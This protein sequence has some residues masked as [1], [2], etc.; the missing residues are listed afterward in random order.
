M[1]LFLITYNFTD[2]INR[3]ITAWRNWAAGRHEL[4]VKYE[5]F[6]KRRREKL[7]KSPV[8]YH[9]EVLFNVSYLVKK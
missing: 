1:M 5:A 7:V 6:L 3:V 9:D 8:G 2:A 4:K